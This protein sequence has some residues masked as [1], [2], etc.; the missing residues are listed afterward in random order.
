MSAVTS[1]CVSCFPVPAITCYG[2]VWLLL[3]LLMGPQHCCIRCYFQGDYSWL[4][5]EAIV[6]VLLYSFIMIYTISMSQ[7]CN[8]FLFY[9]Q[10]IMVLTKQ[11]LVLLLECAN[12]ILTCFSSPGWYL[13]SRSC[14]LILNWCFS[15]SRLDLAFRDAY[16]LI[17]FFYEWTGVICMFELINRY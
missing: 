6:T 17:S 13:W 1:N 5:L 2:M 12:C 3:Y 7:L 9:N 11:L 16:Y 14:F 8:W 4:Y 10:S 15:T